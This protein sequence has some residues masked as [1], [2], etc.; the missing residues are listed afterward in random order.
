M[1]YTYR[2]L[3]LSLEKEEYFETCYNT[4]EPCGPYASEI[5]QTQK[6]RYFVSPHGRHQEKANS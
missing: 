2:E 4:D 5:N 1:V 6:D 3:V